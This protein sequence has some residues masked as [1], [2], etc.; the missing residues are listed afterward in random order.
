MRIENQLQAESWLQKAASDVRSMEILLEAVDPPLDSVCFHA[1]QAAEK[2]LKALLAFYGKPF[3]KTHDLVLLA[4]LLPEEYRLDIE[5]D[6]WAELS[7]F[8][9]GPRYPDDFVEYTRQMAEGLRIKAL[10]VYSEVNRRVQVVR[11]E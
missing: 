5:I 8:A 1:Q 2:S 4:G 11:D 6:D 10:R 3:R 9:V 7:Y